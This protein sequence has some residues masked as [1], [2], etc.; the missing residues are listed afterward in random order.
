MSDTQASTGKILSKKGRPK[1]TQH[2]QQ[3]PLSFFFS[4]SLGIY[5]YIFFM[6]VMKM[7]GRP[8]Y[9]YNLTTYEYLRPTD[10]RFY[11]WYAPRAQQHSLACTRIDKFNQQCLGWNKINARFVLDH[12]TKLIASQQIGTL[13]LLIA[14]RTTT[15]ASARTEEVAV[16]SQYVR[17]YT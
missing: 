9:N 17:M 10:E 12:K 4:L 5:G 16:V 6:V 14:F 15:T 11:R 7:M 2:L 8:Y 1:A 13:L 3:Q